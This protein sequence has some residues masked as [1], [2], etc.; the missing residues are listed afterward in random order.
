MS[1]ALLQ[2]TAV[3]VVAL[4][5]L[6]VIV[7]VLVVFKLFH[8]KK[9]VGLPPPLPVKNPPF[10]NMA[11]SKI[12]VPAVPL[13]PVATMQPQFAAQSLPPLPQA[14]APVTHQPPHTRAP[15]SRGKRMLVAVFS[16]LFLSLSLGASLVVLSHN[17]DI[18]NRAA[19]PEVPLSLPTSTLHPTAG[20]TQPQQ[21][22]SASS[23]SPSCK[24]DTGDANCDTVVNDADYAIWKVTQ[25]Q[26]TQTQAC[27]DIRADFNDDRKIDD[28]DYQVW[29]KNKEGK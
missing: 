3:P 17:Q 16:F 1:S 24:K 29:L 23:I 28:L 2:A 14:P 25:C 4:V 26:P 22:A 27:K 21:A 8:K 6:V 5:V 7:S 18:R 10:F 13:S 20:L 12:A 11:A 9:G 19:E 15:G